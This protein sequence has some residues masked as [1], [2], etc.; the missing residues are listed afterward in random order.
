MV[1]DKANVVE[2]IS[3]D[4]Y[5]ATI[6]IAS[7]N[8]VMES[9]RQGGGEILTCKYTDKVQLQFI[10]YDVDKLKS[11]YPDIEISKVGSRVV[12]QK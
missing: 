7:G 3:V 10:N 8:K 6:G 12:C 2:I 11:I 1:L 5:Q 9:I 4:E